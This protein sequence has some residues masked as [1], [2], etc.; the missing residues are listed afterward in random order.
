MQPA[1]VNKYFVSNNSKGAILKVQY[2]RYNGDLKIC[3]LLHMKIILWRFCIKIPF[4]FEICACD[5]CKKLVYKHSETTENVNN[6]TT[7]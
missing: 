1:F 4:T 6:E 5:I 7:F 3:Y 2:Q